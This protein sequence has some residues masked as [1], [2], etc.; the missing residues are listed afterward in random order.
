MWIISDSE[1][2]KA[3]KLL[4]KGIIYTSEG[5][6]RGRIPEIFYGMIFM[7]LVSHYSLHSKYHT[8]LV[9]KYPTSQINSYTGKQQFCLVILQGSLYM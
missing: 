8:H 2:K 5:E 6:G 3:A 4:E 7:D 9:P 1:L